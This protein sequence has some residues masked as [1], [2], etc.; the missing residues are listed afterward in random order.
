MYGPPP[1]IRALKGYFD[2]QDEQ[3]VWQSYV[4]DMT[5]ALV[6]SRKPKLTV[7]MYSA[8]KKKSRVSDS[9]TGREILEDV[10]KRCRKRKAAREV[11]KQNETV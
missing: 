8:M 11:K 5:W 3:A 6:K 1:S 7:P 10:K 2:M 4:A 9:R